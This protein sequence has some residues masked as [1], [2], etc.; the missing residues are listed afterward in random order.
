M[1]KIK[2]AII[3]DWIVSLGGG[4]KVILKIHEMFPDAPIY[5]SIYN[6]KK[7][8]KY[9]KGIKIYTSFLQHIPFSK[10][11]HRYFL[12]LMPLAFEQ[13]D[14]NDYDL[15]ISSSSCC[16][17]GVNVNANSVHICYCHT[18]MRYAWDMYNMYNNGNIIKKIIIAKQMHKLRQ[19]DYISSN[20]VDYFISNSE[21]VKNRIN[22]HYRRSAKVIYPP[23]DKEF[24]EDFDSAKY[25]C[26]NY[27]LITRLV[28][29][30]KARL[31]VEVFNELRIT[32]NCCRRWTRKEKV[33]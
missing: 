20:R 3:H 21:N 12:P 29:Y 16:A 11:K 1:K 13:F 6:E 23:I 15:V 32:T 24:Y 8:G 17:K 4:E 9:F 14:L 5:T 28:P 26:K 2:V 27:L 30:K 31:V 10:T 33:N 18:P 22:K 19:W 25:E 7:M